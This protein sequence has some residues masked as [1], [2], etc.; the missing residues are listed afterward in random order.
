MKKVQYKLILSENFVEILKSINDP[1]SRKLL[2]L[3]NNSDYGYPMSYIDIT[4]KTDYIKY[5]PAKKVIDNRGNIPENLMWNSSRNEQK[6]GRFISKLI[7]DHPNK[8]EAFVNKFKAE[9]KSLNNLDNFEIVNGNK[10]SRFYHEQSYTPGGGSL[11]KSCMRHDKCQDFFKFYNI[12]PDK[13]SLVVLYEDEK[14]KHILGRALLW[15]IDDPKIQLLDRIYTTKD[16]DQNLFIKLARKNGWYYKSD[17][18]FDST[19]ILDNTGKSVDLKAKVYLRKEKHR[20]FPYLDTFYFYDKINSYITNDVEEY[21]NNKNIVRLRSTDGGDKGNENFVFDTYNNDFI[22][23]S[24]SVSDYNGN[25]I[26]NRDAIKISGGYRTNPNNIRLS[27]YDGKIYLK[28]DTVWSTTHKTFI[29]SKKSFKVFFDEKNRC[30][31]IHSDL[32]GETFD[33]VYDR[34]CY[35]IKELLVKGI[36]DKFYLKKYYNEEEVKKKMVSRSRFD[37]A[38][39]L[40]IYF[41]EFIK[42]ISTKEKFDMDYG[43]F[44][45]TGDR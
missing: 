15:N 41:D 38:S 45:S 7:M 31:F 17:Q 4:D 24:E 20:Y 14:R 39:D 12:N 10:I 36:D 26:L 43:T 11:N 25:L 21:K 9:I 6:I 44:G 28:D 16:S 37:E 42:K 33:Y 22:K 40:N 18:R 35:F 5:T 8:V 3:N 30:D 19:G 1:I 13:V 23:T 29:N 2:F 27:E 32:K 34:D